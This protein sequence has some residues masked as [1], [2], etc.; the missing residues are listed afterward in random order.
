MVRPGFGRETVPLS[1]RPAP[2]RGGCLPA[3]TNPWR[4]RRGPTRYGR[5]PIPFGWKDTAATMELPLRRPGR[6]STGSSIA[7]AGPLLPFTDDLRGL[8]RLFGFDHATGALLS[9]RA[10]YGTG[11]PTRRSAQAFE[12]ARHY[13]CAWAQ[14]DVWVSSVHSK[15]SVAG[16]ARLYC[17]GRVRPFEPDPGRTSP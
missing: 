6:C 1:D 12:T 15:L 13:A 9:Q 11:S 17:P 14:N 4:Y 16:D 8:R 7:L 2:F 10:D 5:L 3:V